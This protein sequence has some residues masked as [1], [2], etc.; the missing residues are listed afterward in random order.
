MALVIKDR[1][2]ETTAVTGTGPASL[3]GKAENCQAFS[4]VMVDG[5]TCPYG[6]VGQGGIQFETGTGTYVAS[7]NL[8]ARTTVDESSNSN[9]L[10]SFSAG[11]KNIFIGDLASNSKQDLTPIYTPSSGGALTVD[12]SAGVNQRIQLTANC[13]FTFTAPPPGSTLAVSLIQDAT[14]SRTVTWP[15]SVKWGTGGSP[16]TL[17]TPP[18]NIDLVRFYFDGAQYVGIGVV[19]DY[20]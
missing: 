12:W 17:S 6:I 8:L 10:V 19:L 4:D 13:T 20:I 18:T 16:P 11:T 7:G 9:A 3:A 14:G 1:V 15:T 5:D 2:M